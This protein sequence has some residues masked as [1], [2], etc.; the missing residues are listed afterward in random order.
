MNHQNNPDAGGRVPIDLEDRGPIARPSLHEA[1]VARVRDMIIEG[2]LPPGSR[3][4]E[5]NLGVEL[6]QQLKGA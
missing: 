6:G 4:H 5:G 2:N 1:I 3:I